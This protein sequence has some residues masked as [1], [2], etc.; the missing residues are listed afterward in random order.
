MPKVE[1]TSQDKPT[2]LE[3]VLRVQGDFR[4]CLAPLHATPLQAGVMLF[5][6][7]Q[8]ESSMTD[9]AAG[10]GVAQPT[11]SVAVRAMIRKRWVSE[12]RTPKDRRVVCLRLTQRGEVL[13]RKIKETIRDM[14]IDL[15]MIK[16]A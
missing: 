6:H 8:R 5:L 13:A 9:T 14:K 16:E 11:L 2:L 10:V 4:Q 15:A 7:R 1:H 3:V 12:H